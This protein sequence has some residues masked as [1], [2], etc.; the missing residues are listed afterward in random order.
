VV[1]LN[2][3]FTS[4]ALGVEVSGEVFTSVRVLVGVVNSRGGGD[5]DNFDDKVSLE[6]AG[7]SDEVYLD[8]GTLVSGD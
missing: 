1:D 7:A 5:D 6:L 2:V 4:W 8:T 3:S